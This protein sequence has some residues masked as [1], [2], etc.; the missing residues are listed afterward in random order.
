VARA[1]AVLALGVTALV[2]VP[3]AVAHVVEVPYLGDAFYALVLLSA[4]AL[5]SLIV[6]SRTVVWACVLAL[7]VG[8]IAAYVVSR[9][10]GLP[11]AADDIGDWANRLGAVAVAAELLAVVVAGGVLRRRRHDR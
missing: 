6:E 11:L 5:G 1:L 8:S 7:G 9:T 2:H 10:I 4:A 3:V